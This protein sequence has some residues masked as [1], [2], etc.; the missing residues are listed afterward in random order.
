ML[1]NIC[2]VIVYISYHGT[3]MADGILTA[4]S[5]ATYIESNVRLRLD[6]KIAG[7][8]RD[9]PA[10]VPRTETLISYYTHFAFYLP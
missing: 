1:L 9:R 10:S 8:I 6:L 3:K 4:D 7:S 5:L 2:F